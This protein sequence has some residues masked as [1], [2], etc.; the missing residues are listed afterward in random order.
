[1]EDL[2]PAAEDNEKIDGTLALLEEQITAF[3]PRFRA[4]CADAIDLLLAELRERV[5]IVACRLTTRM[6]LRL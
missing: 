5:P 6:V 4:E 2:D 3:K 1:M